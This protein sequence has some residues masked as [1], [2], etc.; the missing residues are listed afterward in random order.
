MGYV[1]APYKLLVT[2][3]GDRILY[4]MSTKRE[5]KLRARIQRLEDSLGPTKDLDQRYVDAQM[6]AIRNYANSKAKSNE[7]KV[8][9]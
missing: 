4:F 3:I 9:R 1:K 5:E 2:A 8:N 7:R 6:E